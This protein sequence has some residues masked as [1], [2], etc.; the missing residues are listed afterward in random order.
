[1]IK[2]TTARLKY[3][4]PGALLSVLFLVVM[5]RCSS[6]ALVSQPDL[7][8]TE[9]ESIVPDN[10]TTTDNGYKTDLEK[11]GWSLVWDEEFTGPVVDSTKWEHEVNGDGGGN[12]ELQFYTASIANSYIKDDFLVIKAI[13]RN[14]KGKFYTSAR[15]RSKGKGDWTYGRFD[16]RA[17]LPIQQGVWPAIWMLPTDWTYGSWPQSGE[18]DIMEL[19]GN[20][21]STTYGTIHFGDPWPNNKYIGGFKDLKTGTFEDEFHV[22]SVEWKPDTIKWFLDDSLFATR[23]PSET[24]PKRW[25]FDQRFHMILNLAIGGNWPGPPDETTTFPKYMFVDYVRVYQKK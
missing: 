23:V 8:K 25:P 24:F 10:T 2:I 21:P 3:Y 4:I 1:M 14:Y 6:V 12:N 17:K 13:Q 20:K 18:I 15:L 9:E 7:Y 16:I 11:S 22:F 5:I 19:I